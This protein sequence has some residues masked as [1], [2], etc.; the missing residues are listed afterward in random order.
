MVEDQRQVGACQQ[1]RLTAMRTGQGFASPH[2]GQEFC[3]F[4]DETIAAGV[5]DQILAARLCID[6]MRK[7]L[8]DSSPYVRIA[9]AEA[10][11]RYGDDADATKSAEMLLELAPADKNGAFVSLA[12]L[13]AIDAMGDRASAVRARVAKVVSKDPN[14]HARYGGYGLRLVEH[15]TGAKASGPAE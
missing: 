3:R 8:G 7:A 11:G 1:D 12:A 13:N 6:D 14:A 10:L 4:G 9:V 5:R 15:I 2:A